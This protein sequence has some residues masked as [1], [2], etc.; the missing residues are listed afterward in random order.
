VCDFW[1]GAFS[2]GSR[3]EMEKGHLEEKSVW[4]ARPRF[5][6]RPTQKR[7]MTNNKMGKKR[8]TKSRVK[9]GVGKY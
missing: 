1:I 6:F 8:L 5:H 2:F 7:K 9:I 4:A 3:K